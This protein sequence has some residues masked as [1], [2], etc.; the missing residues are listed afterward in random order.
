MI[1]TSKLTLVVAGCLLAIE[2]SVASAAVIGSDYREAVLA[3]NPV[4]YWEMDEAGGNLADSSG[5]GHTGAAAVGN[6]YSY[7][8]A[9]AFAALGTSVEF[10]GS[11]DGFKVEAA[12]ADTPDFNPIDGDG[13]TVMAWSNATLG[14]G[15]GIVTKGNSRADVDWDLYN[16]QTLE[17]SFRG[18][19]GGTNKWNI[20]SNNDEG[21]GD[22]AMLVGTW[23]GTTNVNGV[24]F[25]VNGTLIAQ[26]TANGDGS[27]TRDIF[28]GGNAGAAGTREYI[29]FLDE[30]AIF[31]T[32]LSASNISDLYAK[33]QLDPDTGGDIPTPAALPAGLA[34]LGFVAARRRRR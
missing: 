1:K 7:S 6:N 2:T 24:K 11:T 18:A 19:S 15:D 27:N 3:L 10:D 29:G 12:L 20:Q 26:A 28:L 8:E 25:Y 9:S 30:V 4:G 22:W 14:N 13:F 23:D 21:I 32:A 31:D 34:L 17:A 16:H 5:G 33:A